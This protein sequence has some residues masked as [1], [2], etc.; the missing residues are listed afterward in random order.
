MLLELFNHA[1]NTGIVPEEWNLSTICPIFKNKGD[2]SECTNYRGIS[3]MSHAGKMYERILE[4]RLRS[5]VEEKL[6]ENQCGFRPDR[7]TVDQIAA[8][9]LVLEKKKLRIRN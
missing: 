5:K 1:W 6:S 7:E 3:L 9:R 2:P 4:R 8:L